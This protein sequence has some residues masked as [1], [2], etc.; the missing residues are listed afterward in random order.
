MRGWITIL[1]WFQV[2][3]YFVMAILLGY[4]GDVSR[5]ITIFLYGLSIITLIVYRQI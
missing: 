5:S 4:T 1:A 3:N 2:I